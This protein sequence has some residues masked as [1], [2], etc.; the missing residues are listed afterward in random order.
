[1]HLIDLPWPR[2]RACLVTGVAVSLLAPLGLNVALAAEGEAQPEAPPAAAP[3]DAALT[4]EDCLRIAAQTQ[5]ALAAYRASLAAAEVQYRGL[6]S[7]HVPT[8]LARDLPIRRKQSCL[9]VQLASAG[10]SQAEW[11]NIYAVT[12]T[13]YGVVYARDQLKVAENVAASLKFYRDRVKELVGKGESREWTTSTV[14]K[15]NIYLRL[16]EIR[17][18]EA[19][20]GRQ[21]AHAALREAMGVPPEQAIRLAL[22]P[23]P[24]PQLDISREQVVA[25]ALARRGEVIE[26]NTAS[27]VVCLEVKAQGTSCRPTFRTFAAA[28]DIHAVPVPQGTNNGEYRPGATSLEMPT[29]MV[30]PRWARVERTQDLSARA[31][32]VVDKTRNLVALEA[33]DAFFKWEEANRKLP[34]TRDAAEAGARLS[35]HTRE[36]FNAGQRVRIEDILTNEVLAGQAQAAYNEAVYEQVIA[37]AN[38]QRATA[39]GFSAGLGGPA[40]PQP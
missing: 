33:E 25:E 27:E 21:R 31:V 18:A 30:G 17:Q 40:A 32:A 19:S 12:R 2:L 29:L 23:M 11:D 4:L 8:F 28:V 22:E 38:L 36:D 15:I 9:G 7:L 34:T 26:A 16:A 35:K 10:L 13:Y 20:R 39:G 37:L 5:P 24:V 6:K 14:D 3:A 1:M